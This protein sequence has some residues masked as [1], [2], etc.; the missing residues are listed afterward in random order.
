ML[1]RGGK[2][3]EKNYTKMIFMTQMQ[4]MGASIK[5]TVFHSPFAIDTDSAFSGG[6]FGGVGGGSGLP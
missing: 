6:I 4:A 2:N 1:R 3:T 5:N